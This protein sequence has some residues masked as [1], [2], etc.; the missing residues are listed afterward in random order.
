MC[1]ARR[2]RC[3]DCSYGQ[4]GTDGTVLHRILHWQGYPHI[5]LRVH[6]LHWPRQGKEDS[7]HSWCY[8]WG[9]MHHYHCSQG[10][11]HSFREGFDR[12]RCRLSRPSLHL[13]VHPSNGLDWWHGAFW[14]PRSPRSREG[15]G[16]L[17]TGGYC[18]QRCGLEDDPGGCAERGLGH[19]Q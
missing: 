2:L 11:V 13:H 3:L 15:M 14:R 9:R 10:R 17:Q 19:L 4:A 6:S 1:F 18:P 12:M 5:H 8:L 7:T 16:Q